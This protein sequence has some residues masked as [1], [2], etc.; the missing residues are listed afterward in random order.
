[1]SI[2]IF[3]DTSNSEEIQELSK[4]PLIQGFTSNPSLMKKAG[5]PDYTE[6]CKKVIEITDKPVSFEVFSDDFDEIE[7]QA[8]II[9]SWGENVYV[10][11]P[12]TNTQ[13]VSSAPLINKLTKDIKLNITAV[14]GLIGADE[15][16][17]ESP[18]IISIFAG[19]IADT[20]TDPAPF[21]NHAVSGAEYLWASTREVFN[22]IQAERA[23]ADIIT[24]TPEIFR[25]YEALKGKDLTEFS[26][27]TVKQFYNDAQ[28]CGFSL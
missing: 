8:R 20:G 14:F 18:M 13:G 28:S 1:M 6:F 21:F 7:R 3:A 27:E 9:S 24:I 11:I 19:R 15:I 10:K 4:N 22:I 26:L 23:G 2:K 17:S 12:I 16:V 5:V 25:K